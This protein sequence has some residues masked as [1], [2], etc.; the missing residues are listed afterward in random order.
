MT[1]TVLLND[2]TS[3]TVYAKSRPTDIGIT[4]WLAVMLCVSKFDI[5]RIYQVEPLPIIR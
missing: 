2:G 5:D 3:R 4:D 1:Y